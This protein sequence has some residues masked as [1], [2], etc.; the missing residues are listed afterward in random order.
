VALREDSASEEGGGV[1]ENMMSSDDDDFAQ[2]MQKRGVG[3]RS[4]AR[5]LGSTSSPPA[6]ANK[7]GV[8][9]KMGAGPERPATIMA[10]AGIGLL[11]ITGSDWAGG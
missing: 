9:T 2:S 7:G 1:R 10:G 5:P 4:T 8:G 11:F 3:K 6:N